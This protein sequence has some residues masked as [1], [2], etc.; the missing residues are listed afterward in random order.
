MNL[1]IGNWI[2]IKGME[3]P[4]RIAAIHLKKFGW[5]SRTDRLNWN[6]FSSVSPIPLDDEILK[7][8]GFILSRDGL[9]WYEKDGESII[10]KTPSGYYIFD[11]VDENKNLSIHFPFRYV[12]ELQNI[13]ETCD[14]KKDIVL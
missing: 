6:N 5:H 4:V 7:L 14:M 9:T 3:K 11:V 12:H 10:F 2:K 13:M 8:N 1:A